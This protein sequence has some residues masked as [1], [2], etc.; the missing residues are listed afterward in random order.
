MR[1]AMVGLSFTIL[2]ETPCADPHAGCCGG[3]GLDTSGYPIK[4]GTFKPL[5]QPDFDDGLSGDTQSC[6][7]FI[8]RSNH[9]LGE[10]NI[11]PP[12]RLVG[13]PNTRQVENVDDVFLAFVKGQA[14]FDPTF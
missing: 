1:Y 9:P 4:G 10:I 2:S 3:W 8:K 11:H 7:F 5:R 13:T 6:R 12:G 14:Q